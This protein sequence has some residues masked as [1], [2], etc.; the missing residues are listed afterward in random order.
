MPLDCLACYALNRHRHDRQLAGLTDLSRLMLMGGRLQC[1]GHRRTARFVQEYTVISNHQ[2]TM[3]I[4]RFNKIDGAFPNHMTCV[5]IQ[6]VDAPLTA[7]VSG[8]KQ[9]IAS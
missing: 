9:D 6:G 5:D 3:R 7:R 1:C 2:S 8:Y 4:A